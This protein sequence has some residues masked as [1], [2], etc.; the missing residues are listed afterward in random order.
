ML[1]LCNTGYPTTPCR[2]SLCHRLKQQVLKKRRALL[3]QSLVPGARVYAHVCVS[4]RKQVLAVPGS[5]AA[6]TG[7]TIAF[8]SSSY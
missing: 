2:A 3:K 8:F 5:L 4:L 7:I 6:T 1:Q